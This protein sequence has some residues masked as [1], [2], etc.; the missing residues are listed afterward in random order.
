VRITVENAFGQTQ[1]LWTYTAFNKG[2]KA[3]WQPVAA[4]FAVAILLSNCLTCIRGNSISGR[5]FL[6]PPTVEAYLQ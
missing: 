1:Q 4:Y 5:F 6:P 2:L 3:G